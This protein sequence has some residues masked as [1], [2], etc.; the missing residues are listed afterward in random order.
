LVVVPCGPVGGFTDRHQPTPGDNEG[1]SLATVEDDAPVSEA[2]PGIVKEL[3]DL[4]SGEMN[5]LDQA[6]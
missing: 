5:I 1:L 2:M 6:K 3:S 4:M